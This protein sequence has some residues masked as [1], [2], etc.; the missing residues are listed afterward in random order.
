MARTEERKA[1]LRAEIAA[2]P[3]WYHAIDLGDGIR[4]PGA[5]DMG[6]Y[7]DRYPLPE[8]MDGMRVLDVGASN[9]FFAA[10]F[11]RRGAA[12]VVALDL[13][14]WAAH[15]WSPRQRRR[16]ERY[17]A[18][19]KAEFDRKVM[20]QGFDLVMRELGCRRVEKVELTI[21]DVSPER[22]GCFDLVFSGSMLMHVRDPLLGLHAM[23][24]VCGGPGGGAS[25]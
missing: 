20:R 19:E 7:L 4:T 5:L 12:E 25:S 17:S 1:A 6:A 16:L 23:R 21:Y 22:L 18:A 13:P 14:S 15:D 8:R 2:V 10:E 3:A 9:G 11:E 24:S